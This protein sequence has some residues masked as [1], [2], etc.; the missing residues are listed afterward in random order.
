MIQ[1]KKKFGQNFLKDSS[2]VEKIIQSMSCENALVEIGPGLGDL[3]EKLLNVTDVKAYEVDNDL[4]VYLKEKFFEQIKDGKFQ[5]I[6]QDVLKAWEE[7]SLN[8]SDYDIVANLP[9]YIATAIILKALKDD[10]CKSLTVMIQK[11]VASKFAAN[12][13]QKEFCALSVIAQSVA[14]VDVLFDVPSTAFEPEPK[15]VSSVIRFKKFKEKDVE[16]KSNEK[17]EKFLKTAFAQPRK[18]LM[19]N[20]SSAYSKSHLQT[21]F[22]ELSL[23]LNVRGH[24]VD[25]QTYHNL[26]KKL[27]KVTDDGKS[28][29]QKQGR[30]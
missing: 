26:F 29:K 14:D 2:I 15:V 8:D 18:T 19:K 30:E 20:L 23:P 16:F 3:T 17:F 4:S 24:E 7:A 28:T 21:F 13:K 5:L 12:P 9:Y 10:L 27:I 11:E 1:A 6:E 22:Q 25:T